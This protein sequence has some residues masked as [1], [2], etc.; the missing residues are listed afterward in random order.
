MVVLPDHLH[1]L[2]RLPEHDA[3]FSTRW[4]LVKARFSRFIAP[5][6]QISPSRQRRAERGIWQRRYWEHLNRDERD[7]RNHVDYI[8]INPVK[9]RLVAR[10]VDWPHS[11]LHRFVREGRC[12]PTWAAEP[13]ILDMDRE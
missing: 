11:S 9:H 8:H 4:R 1:C 13:F 12:D 3:D 6:E 7:W 5:C 10:A 2:W